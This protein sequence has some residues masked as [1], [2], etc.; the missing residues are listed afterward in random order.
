MNIAHNYAKPYREME[1]V[2]TQRITMFLS[3]N[4]SIHIQN[5]KFH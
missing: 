4:R 2:Q 1:I 3:Q 5:L